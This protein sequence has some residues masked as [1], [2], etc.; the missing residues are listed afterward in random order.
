MLNDILMLR[1]LTS[2][3][4]RVSILCLYSDRVILIQ[5]C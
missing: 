4:H 1:L 3:Q 2:V 5:D